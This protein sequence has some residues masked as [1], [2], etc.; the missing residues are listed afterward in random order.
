[1]EKETQMSMKTWSTVAVVLAVSL[2]AVAARSAPLLGGA[3]SAIASAL[4]HANGI[5]NIAYRRCWEHDGRKHCHWYR[6]TYRG[7]DAQG[8]YQNDIS[9]LPVGSPAWWRQML[10]EDRVRN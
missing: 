8:H 4:D 1:M 3:Q 7:N 2:Y 6:D 10:R 9:E 5:A